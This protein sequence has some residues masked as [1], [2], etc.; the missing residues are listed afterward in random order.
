MYPVD[1]LLGQQF[2]RL[3]VREFLGRN[4][5]NRPIWSCRCSCGNEVEVLGRNLT[6]GIT[7][8][9]GCYRRDV[10]SK[11]RRLDLSNRWFGRLRVIRSIGSRSGR[12]FWKCLCSC[13]NVTDVESSSLVRG[14]TTS[15]GCARYE[16][17]TASSTTHGM[18]HLPEYSTWKSIR[19]RC[20]VETSKDYKDYGGRGI[21]ICDTW[22]ESFENF[23]ADMGPRPSPNHSIDRENNN[24]NYEPGNCRWTTAEEQ[25]LNKRTTRYVIYHGESIPM[26]QLARTHGINY[27]RLKYLLN[28][29]YSAEDAVATIINEKRVI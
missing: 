12:Q 6:G 9:C 27:S 2:G 8:S 23:Y 7:R 10:L 11:T 21:K 4:N 1:D 3:I 28:K 13:G 24:G 14:N 20:L 5:E 29:G 25:A 15:C 17:A 19:R 16:N 18:S 26:V 22:I